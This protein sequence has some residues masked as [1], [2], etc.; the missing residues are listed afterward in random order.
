MLTA[1]AIVCCY[2][3]CWTAEDELRNKEAVH[4]AKEHERPAQSGRVLLEE[5]ILDVLGSDKIPLTCSQYR[6]LFFHIVNQ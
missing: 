5:Q 6:L 2:R 3:K 1:V 4:I